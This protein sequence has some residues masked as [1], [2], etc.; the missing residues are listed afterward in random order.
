MVNTFYLGYKL[1]K[2]EKLFWG[3][4]CP[5]NPLPVSFY[6]A[7]IQDPLQSFRIAFKVNG[8]CDIRVYQFVFLKKHGTEMGM[9]QSNSDL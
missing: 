7:I 3:L 2:F 1:S 9:V 8:K 6:M 4:E 5:L